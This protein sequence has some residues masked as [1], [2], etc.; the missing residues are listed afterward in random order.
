M[1]KKFEEFFM[2]EEAQLE[3][4]EIM[5]SPETVAVVGASSREGSIG[6]AILQNLLQ[7]GFEGTIYPVNS[8]A[9]SV[10]GIRAY[11]KMKDI[12]DTIDLAVIVVPSKY[13]LDIIKEAAEL[14]VK[15]AVIITA[16][17]REISEEGIEMENKFKEIADTVNM[18]LIGP[19]CMGILQ[20]HKP[21]L[22][23]TFSPQSPISGRI[24]FISQSGAL[25]VVVIDYATQLGL[26]FSKFVS[27]GNKADVNGTDMIRNLG[28]DPNTDV[29]LAYLESFS[30]PWHFSEV[31]QAT[32]R[33]KPIILVKSGRT[34]AGARAASS[35][36]GALASVETALEA[37]LNTS[38]VIRVA[39]VE[40]LFSCAAAF[41]KLPLP[42]G[43]NV[44]VVTN[45]GGPSTLAV[46]S[47]IA[48]GL[49]LAKFS[50]ETIENI[51]PNVAAEA[52][53]NNPIDLIASGGPEQYRIALNG[54]LEDENVDSVILIFVPPLIV[55]T[56]EV[57][58][59]IEECVTSHN[60]PVLG[61]IMGRNELVENRALTYHFPMYAFP[62]SAV[63]ALRAMT[64]YSN[65]RKSPIEEIEDI[66]PPSVETD[67][68]I[69]RAQQSEDFVDYLS[70][71]DVEII[72]KE[73]GFK[74][75]KSKI[76]SDGM[77]LIK[78]FKEIDSPVVLKMATK[79]ITH[80]TDKG[81]VMVDVRTEDELL[82]AF[83]K[84]HKIYDMESVP[85]NDRAVLIQKYYAGG[86]EMALGVTVDVQFGPLIMVGSGGVLIEVLD[87][88]SFGRVPITQTRARNMIRKLKGY[89]LLLGYRGDNPVDLQK[90]ERAVI[91][92][93]ELASD[94]RDIIELDINPLLALEIGDEPVV[95]DARIRIKK[96]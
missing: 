89:P 76:V 35:H 1:I 91:Q 39:S 87:D 20:G 3:N 67:K 64:V 24:G 32:S 25:G 72:L 69:E 41:S 54:V 11:P 92:L 19:N 83:D 5:F 16:G 36:T 46:D 63:L 13:V 94:H 96:S 61:V 51:R 70:Q 49:Q 43:P 81:G 48:Q 93:S 7:F 2:D 4:L 28:N 66:I 60:K 85:D 45:A 21:F 75:P 53:L 84:I 68:I 65:W 34:A 82:K 95:L 6:K 47:L 18:R 77:G 23:A 17:F 31:A 42:N 55:N 26:G 50:D 79:S 27:L 15:G 78:A 37:T 90:L 80:K 71:E 56:L 14:K 22:N 44:A 10:M 12:P 30:D 62:E 52:S 73:Y 9:K 33:K 57:A 86:V 74:F 29:I 38:G 8:R 58:K 40:D 88:V 59:V